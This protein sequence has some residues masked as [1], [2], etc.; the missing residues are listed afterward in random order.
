MRPTLQKK[1]VKLLTEMSLPIIQI[2]IQLHSVTILLDI[3]H[4]LLQWQLN[5]NHSQFRHQVPAT[6]RWPAASDDIDGCS[7][8]PSIGLEC[9][10]HF[11][12][13]LQRIVPVV[14]KLVIFWIQLLQTHIE[15]SLGT[16][17]FPNGKD[18]NRRTA[19]DPGLSC[20]TVDP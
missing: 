2:L 11:A 1:M 18:R 16:F 12:P 5:Q 4:P 6:N 3:V 10:Y 8:C 14:P 9:N 7:G 15:C 19:I 20:L 13:K 17:Q